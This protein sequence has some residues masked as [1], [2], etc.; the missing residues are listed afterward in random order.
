MTT[1]AKTNRQRNHDDMTARIRDIAMRQFAE[2]GAAGLS[3]SAIAREIGVTQPALFRYVE[4]RDA[5]ITELVIA[6]YDDFIIAMSVP[7]DLSVIEVGLQ[8]GRALRAWALAN[9]HHYQLIFGTPIPGYRAPKDKT[10]DVD[11]RLYRVLMEPLMGVREEQSISGG[12]HR[13]DSWAEGAGLGQ[14]SGWKVM[15]ALIGWTRLHGILALE[16]AGHFTEDLPDPTLIY[17]A[18]LE[19]LTL[20]LKSHLHTE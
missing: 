3:M 15:H 11:E 2:N 9:P 17:E 14:G 18:E 6:A 8:Q 7:E 5:L 20:N 19:A 16:L 13:L 4:N 10:R 1:G 12:D